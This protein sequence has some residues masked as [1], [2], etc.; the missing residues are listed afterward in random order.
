M[1]CSFHLSMSAQSDIAGIL[2]QVLAPT[3]QISMHIANETV[4]KVYFGRFFN[5]TYNK[6]KRL[7]APK[8]HFWG[9]STVSMAMCIL[10]I[11]FSN[12]KLAENWSPK[13]EILG[14]KW[15]FFD[16]R[17]MILAFLANCQSGLVH[18]HRQSVVI[19]TLPEGKGF[20]TP[21]D[22]VYKMKIR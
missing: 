5:I 3:G 17:W 15:S 11:F 8:S 14:L 12:I 16:F 19:K 20:M 18:F 6:I 10:P 7:E 13:N 4:G 21:L 9:F 2:A 22:T 1:G